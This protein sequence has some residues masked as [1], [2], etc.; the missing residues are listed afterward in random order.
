MNGDSHD[1]AS[2]PRLSGCVPS[3]AAE[4]GGGAV[5]TL[6]YVQNNLLKHPKAMVGVAVVGFYRDDEVSAAKQC[7]YAFVE[8]LASKPDGLPRLIKRQPGDNKRRLDCDDILSMYTA[9]DA[10]QVVLPQYV[11]GNLQ[12]LPSVSP[13]EVDIYALAANVASLTQAT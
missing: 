1:A 12:R 8:A 6:C 4:D 10:A 5:V 3:P 9:L 13:G 7:L 2:Q 11:A